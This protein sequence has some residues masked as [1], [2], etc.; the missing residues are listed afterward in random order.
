M[1]KI[2]FAFLLMIF[3][4]PAFAITVEVK[5]AGYNE[6]IIS[7]I[8]YNLL[9]SNRIPCKV[10]FFVIDNTKL[11]NASTYY[12]DGV[13]AVYDSV[14]KYA[15]DENEIAGILAHEISHAVDF[16]QGIFKGTFSFFNLATFND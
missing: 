6:K 15:K 4:L 7:E 5:K 10:T 8:G 3:S 1:K 11:P 2:I 16:R 14:V 13:I 12:S 9:N